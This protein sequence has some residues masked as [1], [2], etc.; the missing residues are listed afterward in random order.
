M[1]TRANKSKLTLFFF[2]N[3]T[4]LYQM[5]NTESVLSNADD[6]EREVMEAA[7]ADSA[8]TIVALRY[9]LGFPV[10]NRIDS[11]SQGFYNS[12]PFVIMFKAMKCPE[13]SS[14]TGQVGYKTYEEYRSMECPSLHL[15]T[16]SLYNFLVEEYPSDMSIPK[17]DASGFDGFTGITGVNDFF[18]LLA[19]LLEI[20]NEE[21]FLDFEKMP[22]L[23]NYY[24]EMTLGDGGLAFSEMLISAYQG[25]AQ[26]KKPDEEDQAF[27]TQLFINLNQMIS[28]NEK[29]AWFIDSDPDNEG[30]PVEKI[31]LTLNEA[32]QMM[33]EEDFDYRRIGFG[34]STFE[35]LEGEEGLQMIKESM[36]DMIFNYYFEKINDSEV[37]YSYLLNVIAGLLSNEEDQEINKRRV[38]MIYR[39]VVLEKLLYCSIKEEKPS[40]LAKILAEKKINFHNL[41]R[42]A[43]ETYLEGA[44]KMTG[45]F[46]SYN[47][48]FCTP[49]QAFSEFYETYTNFRENVPIVGPTGFMMMLF[50]SKPH[51]LVSYHSEI[52][53]RMEMLDY[54]D[55]HLLEMGDSA[56]CF[57]NLVQPI[58][59]NVFMM[60]MNEVDEDGLEEKGM[61]PIPQE[62]YY[63]YL[64]DLVN[65]G[66]SSIHLKKKDMLN[67]F[68]SMGQPDL[69]TLCYNQQKMEGLYYKPIIKAIDTAVFKKFPPK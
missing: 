39:Q 16:I 50:D 29:V 11:I 49:Q 32:K 17:E 12:L 20:D 23:L 2:L 68:G 52:T 15:K 33:I 1:Q 53:T 46:L 4:S 5:A 7:E 61:F 51:D 43:L 63:V 59:L 38:K 24:R 62:M 8:G 27:I 45:C 34:E 48:V 21:E 66:F 28:E 30:A 67:S 40:L 41:P 6:M 26:F 18:P 42:V 55:G 36:N 37:V 54:T 3:L 13:E 25:G 19:F 56:A 22:D 60:H 44:S 14:L 64:D 57:F 58:S 47:A 10:A 9:L 69:K 65:T 31:E 35:M